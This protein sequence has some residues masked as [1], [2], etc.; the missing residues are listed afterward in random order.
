MC[1]YPASGNSTLTAYQ[2]TAVVFVV[3]IFCVVFVVFMNFRSFCTRGMITLWLAWNKAE[4]GDQNIDFTQRQVQGDDAELKSGACKVTKAELILK[5]RK[6]FMKIDHDRTK[7]KGQPGFIRGLLL[8]N[9]CNL[10]NGLM[11]DT[12]HVYFCFNF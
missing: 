3:S 1:T 5:G 10:A 9:D 7:T 11:G 12:L 8:C 2:A 6:C 4:A